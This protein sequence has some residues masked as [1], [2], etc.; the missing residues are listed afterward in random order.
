MGDL[1]VGESAVSTL[2]RIEQST[3]S[4]Q[5]KLFELQAFISKNDLFIK[6]LQGTLSDE[7]TA[8]KS[9]ELASRKHELEDNRNAIMRLSSIKQ[10]KEADLNLKTV[11]T[12]MF[13][14]NRSHCTI[15]EG[16]S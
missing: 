1:V 6:Q 5:N 2:E 15:C 16:T 14:Y 11:I 10:Y 13:L 12:I 7:K 9:F 4:K 8:S 3:A